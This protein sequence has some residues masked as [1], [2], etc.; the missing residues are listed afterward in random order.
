[1]RA[2]ESSGD[3][4]GWALASTVAT[5]A[6]RLD[7]KEQSGSFLFSYA[8]YFAHVSWCEHRRV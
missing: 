4:I 1:M 7:K 8:L 3:F 2:G 6:K 5:R